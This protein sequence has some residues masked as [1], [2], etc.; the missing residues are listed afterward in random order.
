[1]SSNQR[2]TSEQPETRRTIQTSMNNFTTFFPPIIQH[3]GYVD[4]IKI[5]ENIRV[6]S[7][8]PRG[9]NLWNNYRMEMLLESCKKYQINVLLLCETQVK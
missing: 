9:I 2:N 6:L 4:N 7:I 8:N 3:K 1:M 5:N